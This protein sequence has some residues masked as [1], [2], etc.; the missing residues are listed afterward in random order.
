MFIYIC[1]APLHFQ[2]TKNINNWNFEMICL[3][4]CSCWQFVFVCWWFVIVCWQFV[5]ICG[6]L[7]V[8]RHGLLVAYDYLCLFG[9]VFG[10]SWSL[11]VLLTTQFNFP[12][13][14]YVLNCVIYDTA[15]PSKQLQKQ[16]TTTKKYKLPAN[17]HKP[18][19]NDHKSPVNDHKIQK[20]YHKRPPLHI[21]LK[22]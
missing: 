18:P 6:C 17:N 20:N 22:S 11:P 9:L 21:K 10:G 8:V 12:F 16:G 19:A 14:D 4:A 15:L 1:Q 3:V 7:V 2:F 5:L 13:L